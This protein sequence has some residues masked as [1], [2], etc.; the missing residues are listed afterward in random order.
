MKRPGYTDADFTKSTAITHWFMGVGFAG[1]TAWVS[2]YL[3]WPWIFD[4]NHPD[5]NPMIALPVL[6]IA[7]TSRELFKAVRWTLR[8]R[9][10]G[11][12]TMELKGSGSVRLGGR[13]EGHVRTVTALRPEGDFR[14]VL[15]CIETHAFREMRDDVRRTHRNE[16]FTVWT[17]EVRVPAEGLDSTRGI[18]FSFQLPDSVGPRASYVPP[19]APASAS[20][21][22]MEFKGAITI[23]GMRRIWTHNAPPTA[24]TWQLDISAPMP[25]TD[26][27]AQFIVPVQQD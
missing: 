27:H 1:V 8:Q 26:F 12:A 9:K 15:Q 16:Q 20:G 23:P 17:Q 19:P 7:A 3:P 6:L 24:R 18:P 25:G 10:F 22:R 13:L 2:S 4:I 5:F 11:T 21:I 14:V